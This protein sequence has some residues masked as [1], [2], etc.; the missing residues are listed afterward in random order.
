M[1]AVVEVRYWRDPVTGDVL[2]E[3]TF[4]DGTVT[5]PMPDGAAAASEQDYYVGLGAGDEAIASWVSRGL[6]AAG[7][8]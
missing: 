4:D 1:S 7:K 8:Q 6:Q 2:K 5:Y 3:E